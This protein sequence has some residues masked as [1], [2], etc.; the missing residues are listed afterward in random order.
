[1]P[2]LASL[3]ALFVVISLFEKRTV[4]RVIALPA[5]LLFAGAAWAF[6][7]SVRLPPY[8]GP[9]AVGRPFPS[10]ET[11]LSDGTQFTERDLTG[12]QKSALVFFR[13]RW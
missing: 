4:W 1:M 5:V 10:F 11:R 6:L 13:G 12:S 9:V 7:L 3:G 8:T 2:I